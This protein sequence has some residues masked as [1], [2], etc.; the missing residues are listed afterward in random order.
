MAKP[1]PKAPA[2]KNAATKVQAEPCCQAPSEEEVCCQVSGGAEESGTTALE[3][4][5]KK[6]EDIAASKAKKRQKTN[7]LTTP[8]ASPMRSSA[9][10][11]AAAPR[12]S[13]PRSPSMTAPPP[14]PTSAAVSPERHGST[15]PTPTSPIT[16]TPPP[17]EVTSSATEDGFERDRARSDSEDLQTET[18]SDGEG[19]NGG[20]VCEGVSG[21]VE[22]SDVAAQTVDAR[23]ERQWDILDKS[24]MV[25]FAKGETNMADMRS[26]GWMFDSDDFPPDQRY[27]GLYDGAY[28]P[29]DEVMSLANSPL[30]LFFFFMPKTKEWFLHREVKKPDVEPHQVLGLLMARM[31]NPHRRRFRD[32]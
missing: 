20:R 28:G 4:A 25:E 16:A 9:E 22:Q 7:V 27:P 18:S 15:T 6:L 24:E 8:E 12:S 2:K 14:T 11:A 21:L 13:P 29:T 31:L 10:A 30:K 19:D 5:R 32:H 3:E 26:S 1:S 23:T 17:R